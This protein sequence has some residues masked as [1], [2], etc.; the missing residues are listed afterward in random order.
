MFNALN[1]RKD[2]LFLNSSVM[3]PSIHAILT[4][5]SGLGRNGRSLHRFLSYLA[6]GAFV[7]VLRVLYFVD[8]SRVDPAL[9]EARLWSGTDMLTFHEW[10]MR[11]ASGDLLYLSLGPFPQAPLY[12]YFVGA[13]YAIAGTRPL[14]VFVAQTILGVVATLLIL[15]IGELRFSF[16]TGIVAALLWSLYP[17]PM[18]LDTKLLLGSVLVVLTLGILLADH[19][20]TIRASTLRHAM[21][22]AITALLVLARPDFSL[23][24]AYVLSTML[25]ARSI[26]GSMRIRRA[27]AFLLP[28]VCVVIAVVIRNRL[29]GGSSITIATNGA[30]N[31]FTGNVPL[32]LDRPDISAL[33]TELYAK[34]GVHVPWFRLT[35][36]AIAEHPLK[37]LL[38]LFRK[39]LQFWNHY[40]LPD[41]VNTYFLRELVLTARCMPISYGVIASLGIV[42]IV[43]NMERWRRL[44]LLYVVITMTFASLTS[45]FVV[46]RYRLPT[47]AV[48]TLYAGSVVTQIFREVHRRRYATLAALLGGVAGAACFVHLP[49]VSHRAGIEVAWSWNYARIYREAGD[50]QGSVTYIRRALALRPTESGY[51]LLSNSYLEMGDMELAGLAL[52]DGLGQFPRSPELVSRWNAF[53]SVAAGDPEVLS[54]FER[55]AVRSPAEPRF[56]VAFAEA[57][58][59]NGRL[60]DA[61]DLLVRLHRED[62]HTRSVHLAL[63]EYMLKA[64][65]YDD[66]IRAATEFVSLYPQDASSWYL[67][68]RVEAAS[69]DASSAAGAIKRAVQLGGEPIMT[70]A[71][72]DPVFK[73]PFIEEVIEDVIGD[74]P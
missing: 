34:Y 4:H 17:V 61:I 56:Q 32:L 71:R 64:R 54:V 7:A 42:G 40:E 38:V 1:T 74:R 55:W 44:H 52:A 27:A 70:M 51:V 10:G 31:F 57:L 49:Q 36:D 9:L 25:L 8:A 6:L 39:S 12:P 14:A 29:A 37:W 24:A 43:A 58:S 21:F 60:S 67:L 15:R 16:R 66:A 62:R 48:L 45:L 18:I 50:P 20:V 22:G 63:V 2:A 33:E 13:I 68:A 23:V 73:A 65:R 41:N 5:G 35:L 46:D 69:G 19:A 72:M 3:I 26:P 47:T 30:E 53:V 11:V 28:L 59:R